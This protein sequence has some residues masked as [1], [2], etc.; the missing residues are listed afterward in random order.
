MNQTALTLPDLIKYLWRGKFYIAVGIAVAA[1]VAT[2][3]IYTAVLHQKSTMIISPASPMSGS[4]TS[5]LLADDRLFALRYL[6]QRVGSLGANDFLN[7]E[8]T[9]SGVRVAQKLLTD[10]LIKT[11]LEY[12]RSFSFMDP[13]TVNTPEKLAAYI[14]DRVHLTPVG[15]S[16]LRRVSYTHPDGRFAEYFIT[17]IHNT[18]DTL[19]RQNIK[20][21]AA[22]RANYLQETLAQ[23]NNP[24]HRRSLTTLL[25][26]QERL[27]MLVSLD[28]PY[29]A[30]IIEPA[31]IE[32]KPS[33]PD[34]P[35]VLAGFLL[36]GAL[37]GFMTFHMITLISQPQS[38]PETPAS[39]RSWDDI[40]RVTGENQNI[41][42]EKR[43]KAS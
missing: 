9:Y 20:T 27:L 8:H 12:D 29:A 34:V 28:T 4:E 24:E 1:V 43:R 5:S 25:L 13:K 16:A 31:S 35:M 32:I 17:Q 26:E 37:I 36:V 40:L 3:F 19:I 23:T 7:F 10:P 41:T 6:A 22:A 38:K 21:Q 11:G 39:P 2:L 15:T 42:P 33:W 14:K 18:T 30:T